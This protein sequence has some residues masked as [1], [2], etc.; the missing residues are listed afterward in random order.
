[1]NGR[2]LRTKS[3][4]ELSE[5]WYGEKGAPVLFRLI[6]G[7]YQELQLLSYESLALPDP[8]G[9]QA[10]VSNCRACVIHRSNGLVV[11]H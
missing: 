4:A 11:C 1:M 10:C 3:D 6:T 9:F 8:E 2:L 5:G 7:E